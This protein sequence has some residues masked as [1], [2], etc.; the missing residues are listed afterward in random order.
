VEQQRRENGAVALALDRIGRRRV[1]QLARLVV[2]EGRRLAFAA[3]RPRPFDALHRV[4]G[5]GVLLTQM[6][7]QRHERGKP[8]SDRGPAKR[9]PHQDIPPRDDVSARHPVKLLGPGD[10]GEAHEVA[11]CVLIGAASARV[12]KIGEP[13]ALGR[14]GGELVEIERLR[15]ILRDDLHSMPDTIARAVPTNFCW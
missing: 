13:L 14:H 7:E 1:Q 12:A 4:V 6:F 5:D 8:V 2:A 15:R 10:A 9:A 3:F 11:D